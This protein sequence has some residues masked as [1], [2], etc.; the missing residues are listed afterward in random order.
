M[1]IENAKCLCDT[2]KPGSRSGKIPAMRILAGVLMLAAWYL[3]YRELSPFSNWLAYRAM[4]FSAQS[5]IGSSI[6]FFVFEAPKVLMLLTLVV[7][8]VGVVR[9][10]FHPGANAKNSCGQERID[11]QCARGIAGNCHAFLLMLRSA[12][13]HRICNHRHSAWSD[14]L[15]PHFGPD[16]E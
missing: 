4:G 6:Q 14:I 5:R 10:I 11:R 7:F 8:G 16:G 1:S 15:V 3:M 2:G 13:I 9:I 12:F